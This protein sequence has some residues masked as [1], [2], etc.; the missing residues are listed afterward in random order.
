MKL[1]AAVLILLCQTLFAQV[2]LEGRVRDANS[3]RD[4]PGVNVYLVIDSELETSR[5]EPL[6]IDA[7]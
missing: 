7:G 6:R 4:I 2:V 1:F 3:H 5:K